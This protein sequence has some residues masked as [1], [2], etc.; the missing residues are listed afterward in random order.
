M[1]LVAD[2]PRPGH[3]QLHEES[4]HRQAIVW[5]AN[6]VKHAADPLQKKEDANSNIVDP[7]PEEQ[8]WPPKKKKNRKFLFEELEGLC[9][10]L[11]EY[12]EAWKS[13]K[14]IYNKKKVTAFFIKKKVRRC[15]SDRTADPVPSVCST[16]VLVQWVS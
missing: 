12:F 4:V 2:D 13:F 8:K 14:E 9:R 6:V 16:W 10:V 5:G 15:H 1:Y 3:Q 7:D 11:H